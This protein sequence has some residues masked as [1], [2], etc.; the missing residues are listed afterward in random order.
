MASMLFHLLIAVAT[1]QVLSLLL[2][3]VIIIAM[4]TLNTSFLLINIEKWA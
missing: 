1:Y 4:I 3:G 2:Q